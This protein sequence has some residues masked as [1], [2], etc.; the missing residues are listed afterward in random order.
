MAKYR[1]RI[2][3]N[4][5]YF[6]GFSVLKSPA[7]DKEAGVISFCLNCSYRL[8]MHT[9]LNGIRRAASKFRGGRLKL[10]T[11]FDVDHPTGPAH[12]S[13]NA[14]ESRNNP[15]IPPENYSCHLRVVGQQLEKERID[16]FNLECTENGYAVRTR[17]KSLMGAQDRWWRSRN[18][19]TSAYPT[20][21][22][23]DSRAEYSVEDLARLEYRSR[24]NRDPTGGV[25]NGHSLSQLLRTLGAL[26]SQRHERLLAISWADLSIYVV[27]ETAQRKR[28]IE[29]FRPDN[30][31]DIWVRMYLRRDNRALSDVPQ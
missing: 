19:E 26:V 6:V 4:C 9:I 13:A 30:L 31:Y 24:M 14:F 5:R 12:Q 28:E 2:C 1:A 3:P 27:I 20:A 25:A 17:T 11:N 7:G 15:K 21:P 23:A 22:R 16:T 10:A 29:V 18:Q 8:P